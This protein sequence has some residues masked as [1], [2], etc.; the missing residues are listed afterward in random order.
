MEKFNLLNLLLANSFKI[1]SGFYINSSLFSRSID[2]RARL[3]K[4]F[5]VMVDLLYVL[6]LLIVEKLLSAVALEIGIT[7]IR[8][9]TSSSCKN[10]A[11][12]LLIDK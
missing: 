10:D 8:L 5:P 3:C 9:Y 12:M 6:I 1:S 11:P 7:K 2:S 4:R